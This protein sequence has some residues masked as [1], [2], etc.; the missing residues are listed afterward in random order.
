[1]IRAT[2]G[3][4]F[5]ATTDAFAAGLAGT[6]GV[7]IRDGAGGQFLARTTAGISADVTVG[8]TSVYRRTFTAPTTLG[9]WWIVWDDGTTLKREE[10]V[11]TSSA[12]SPAT[13]SG[14]DL[15]TL[16]DVVRYA[17][18][19][20]SDP[21]TDDT[22]QALI[23]QQ[24]V[25]I[26]E[27][28][29]R[30]YVAIDPELNPRRFD[31]DDWTLRKRK[32]AIG[33]ATSIDTITLYRGNS[34]AGTIET[35][36]VIFEPRVRKAWEPITHLRFPQTSPSPVLLVCEDI[37]ELD[38]A[39]GFPDVPASIRG[40]CEKLVIVRYLTD[41]AAVGTAFADAVTAGGDINIGGLFRS[42]REVVDRASMP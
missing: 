28:T 23:T 4:S 7:R 20:I 6:L 14:S 18:G 34:V 3:A 24:S 32:L 8:A 25:D 29:G 13:P 5:E 33:D 37:L 27:A 21:D 1:M 15:C 26:L 30:E 17:P 38:G 36:D 40:A 31:V 19:Y 41:I 2:P 10:L 12:L 35:P 22:L 39:W 11:V 42:A 9:Q 16:A